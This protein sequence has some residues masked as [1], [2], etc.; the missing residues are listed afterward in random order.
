LRAGREVEKDIAQYE[1]ERK[2]R[3]TRL[4]IT[5]MYNRRDSK[6]RG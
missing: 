1:D 6:G 2:R 3:I 4:G 5:Q